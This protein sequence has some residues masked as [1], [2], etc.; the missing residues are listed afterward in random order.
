M[1]K[2]LDAA[3]DQRAAWE[4]SPHADRR[5]VG[6]VRQARFEQFNLDLKLVKPAATTKQRKI[7]RIPI[8]VTSPPSCAS[9]VCWC[10]RGNPGCSLARRPAGQ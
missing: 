9:A 7:H 2:A 3:N 8:W 10:R 6:E 1:A 5:A 4:S